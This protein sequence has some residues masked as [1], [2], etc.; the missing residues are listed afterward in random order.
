VQREVKASQVLLER[1]D[2]RACP[3]LWVVQEQ[4]VHLELLVH[5]ARLVDLEPQVALVLLVF[6]AQLERLVS[7]ARPE[8]LEHLVSIFIKQFFLFVSL[9]TLLTFAFT[10]AM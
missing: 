7:Q 4:L 3:E 5:L 9:N 10:H 8:P 2:H 1:L 6:L